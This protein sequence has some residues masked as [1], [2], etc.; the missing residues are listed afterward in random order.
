MAFNLNDYETVADRIARFYKDNKDGRIHTDIVTYEGDTVVAQARVYKDASEVIWAT[1]FA[2]EIR[3]KGMVNTTRALE[4]CET[5]AVG[6]ALANAGYSGSK[7]RASREEM[8]KVQRH[9]AAPAPAYQGEY[10]E[11]PAETPPPRDFSGAATAPQIAKIHAMLVE[12]GVTSD[13]NKHKALARFTGKDSFTKLTKQD[14]TKVIE[15]LM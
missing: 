1:G 8:E 14:A 7:Q 6:R 4:N 5:S 2:E 3:G 12:Q 15:G 13:E 10:L 11:A 9:T